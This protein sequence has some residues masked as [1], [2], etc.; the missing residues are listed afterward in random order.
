MSENVSVLLFVCSL[1]F[2]FSCE[3]EETLDFSEDKKLVLLSNFS[4]DSLLRVSLSTTI[5]INGA[6]G[7]T[8]NYPND[9][10][11]EFFEDGIFKEQLSYHSGND[12]IAP[13]YFSNFN[14]KIESNY[15][16]Q[17]KVNDFREIESRGKVPPVVNIQSLSLTDS[18]VVE[19]A[20]ILGRLIYNLSVELLLEN[21][22]DTTQYFHLK[23]YRFIN[24]KTRACNLSTA[25]GT[26]TP[27]LHESGV[28]LRSS[29]FQQGEL[30]VGIDFI[31]N[32]NIE[33]KSPIYLEL[34]HT[35]ENYY[36]FHKS[37]GEQEAFSANQSVFSSEVFFI[38]NNVEN[39]LGN[40]SGY[41]AVLDSLLF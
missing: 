9:A 14:P 4:P 18:T 40:F 8:T 24:G 7:T 1:V 23:A 11:V 25:E 20:N 30:N 33:S 5:A 21:I 39:G 15:L 16:L 34:R 26:G 19:D 22:L 3:E 27:L 29:D 13:F 38:Y 41:S 35:E 2:F 32:E 28:L 12:L 37:I 31:F 36:R 10:V 6:F 17:A